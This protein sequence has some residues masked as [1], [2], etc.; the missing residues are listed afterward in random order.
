MTIR[1]AAAEIAFFWGEAGPDKWFESDE[2]FEVSP[3]L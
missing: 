3:E 2:T 1:V